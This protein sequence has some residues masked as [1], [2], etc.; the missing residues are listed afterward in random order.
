MRITE[1]N[2]IK[3][4]IKEPQSSEAGQQLLWREEM[5]ASFNI[6]V[7]FA[8][9]E[10]QYTFVHLKVIKGKKRCLFQD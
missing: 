4:H 9:S 1:E 5:H 3:M 2:A 6:S 10:I 7:S 8:V